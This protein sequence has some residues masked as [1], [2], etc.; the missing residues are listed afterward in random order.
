MK[1]DKTGEETVLL[2]VRDLK[3]YDGQSLVSAPGTLQVTSGEFLC[4]DGP[5]G[6]GKSTFLKYLAQLIKPNLRVEGRVY[7]HGKAL[8][9]WNP[10]SL[11]RSISYCS[12]APQLF[13]QTVLDNLAFPS[14][15]RGKEF[16][17]GRCRD[18]L[19]A[20]GLPASIIEKEVR[21]LS[22]G[23]KQRV[24]LIRNLLYP[25]E[26]LLLDEITAALDESNRQKIWHLLDQV[27]AESGGTFLLVSH[28]REDRE[29]ADRTLSLEAV[30]E[31]EADHE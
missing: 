9:D 27:R 25:P 28:N 3:I 7:F 31:K 6:S 24:A 30:K 4:I 17:Q 23:E 18:L 20:A 2:R 1:D 14:Q 11:R 10:Q 22:G 16:R 21:G 13:G 26:V 29:R 15:I 19:V 12:Q 5:S 8:E